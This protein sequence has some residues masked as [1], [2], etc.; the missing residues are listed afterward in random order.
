L[1]RLA[2]VLLL[3]GV[4]A[5]AL[6]SLTLYV[7]RGGGTISRAGSSAGQ[8]DTEQTTVGGALT[9]SA[10][11]RLRRWVEGEGADDHD[12]MR[13]WLRDVIT[14]AT[15]DEIDAH[16]GAGG[17][18]QD[19]T[20]GGGAIGGDADSDS[21]IQHAPIGPD[22]PPDA[23]EPWWAGMLGKIL[24]GVGMA[25]IAGFWSWMEYR[26][27][28]RRKGSDVEDGIEVAND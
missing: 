12:V 16:T 18:S 3:I 5:C 15:H 21:R 13:R 25:L 9:F 28:K 6:P 17:G 20:R 14:E 1:N 4:T 2:L 22:P 27:F 7:E 19:D 24:S 10:P 11:S 8:Y 23:D 26:G